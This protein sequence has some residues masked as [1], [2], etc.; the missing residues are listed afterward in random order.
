MF[1]GETSLVDGTTE[2]GNFHVRAHQ[3]NYESAATA[4][5]FDV[6]NKRLH[7]INT[8]MDTIIDYQKY[9]REQENLYR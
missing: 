9:E 7:K 2:S 4:G 1:D 3:D 8:A 6:L 5:Q